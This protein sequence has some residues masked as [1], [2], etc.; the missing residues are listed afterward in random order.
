MAD[1]RKGFRAGVSSCELGG[2][3]QKPERATETRHGEELSEGPCAGGN[4]GVPSG[5]G[6]EGG[7]A[8]KLNGALTR[9]EVPARGSPGKNV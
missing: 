9:T 4:L 3:D 8:G 1:A 5:F 7:K 6:E 2:G